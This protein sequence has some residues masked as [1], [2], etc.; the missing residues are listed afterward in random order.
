MA[1]SEQVLEVLKQRQ[2]FIENELAGK[3]TLINNQHKEAVNLAN[4][5]H[6]EALALADKSKNEALS[7]FNSLEDELKKIKAFQTTGN[8]SSKSSKSTKEP[9]AL[10]N[11][12]VPTSKEAAKSNNDKILY[13]VSQFDD[14]VNNNDIKAKIDEDF[15]GFKSNV[16]DLTGKLEALGSLKSERR[17]GKKFYTLA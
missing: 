3:T 2:T 7:E 8:E 14:Y 1:T 6:K 10:K 4:K 16:S 5:A 12:E 9:K 13:A 17:E 15:P 11:I